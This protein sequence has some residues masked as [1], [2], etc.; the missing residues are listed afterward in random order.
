VR[1]DRG[2]CLPE[3]GVAHATGY[4]FR[5]GLTLWTR[6]IKGN[7]PRG[8]SSGGGDRSRVRNNGR[9]APTFGDIDN[10]LERSASDDI[11]LRGGGTTHRRATWCWLGTAGSPTE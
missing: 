2:G 3:L 6:R 7:S 9:L 8:S 11:R 1:L 4:R 10:K 5:Q